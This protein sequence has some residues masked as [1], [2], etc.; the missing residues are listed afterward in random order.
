MKAFNFSGSLTAGLP[1]TANEKFGKSLFLGEEGRGRRYEW[2][3]LDNRFPP[4]VVGDRVLECEPRKVT[5]PPKDGKPEKVFYVLEKAKKV[6]SSVLVRINTE[7]TYTR[8]THGRMSVVE[9]TPETLVSGSGAYGDAGRIGVWVDSLVVM[10]PGDAVKVILSGGSKFEPYAIWMEKDGQEPQTSTWKEYETL[11]A[12]TEA[13]ALVSQTGLNVLFGQMPAYNWACGKLELGIELAN[14]LAGQA[15]KLGQEGR[16]RTQIEL[17]LVNSSVE[18]KLTEAAV[19]KL[20]EKVVPARYFGDEPTTK[21]F[22]G[23]TQVPEKE[24]GFLVKISTSWVYTRGSNAEVSTW[25]GNPTFIAEG[26]G[27]EGAAGNIYSWPEVVV[28]LHE[29]DVIYIRPEG[30]Y[31]T[32]SSALFVKGGKLQS[33]VWL[34]WKIE[35]AKRDPQ[36]YVAKG[37]APLGHVPTDWIGKVVTVVDV[38]TDRDRHSQYLDNKETGEVIS[39]NP[40]ILNLGWDGQDRSDREITH[41]TWIRLETEKQVKRLEGAE[42]EKRAQVRAKL[43]GLMAKAKMA[44]EKSYFGLAED[45]LRQ[46]IYDVSRCFYYDPDT[47]P[48]DLSGLGYSLAGFIEKAEGIMGRFGVVEPELQAREASG[49]SGE[50]LPDYKVSLGGSKN[51][52]AKETIW[53]IMPDGTVISPKNVDYSEAKFGDLP[54]TVLVVSWLVDNYGY[55]YS[56]A[57]RVKYL[58]KGVTDAQKA[59]VVKLEQSCHKY[60]VGGKTGW[61]LTEKEVYFQTAYERDFQGEEK[62]AMKGMASSIW[63]ENSTPIDLSIWKVMKS[64]TSGKRTVWPERRTVGDPNHPSE[65]MASA[66]KKAVA[67]NLDE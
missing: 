26:R 56:E 59:K 47:L 34:N 66:Y 25:K 38:A 27:A 14:G 37:T 20:S 1:L 3:R 57:W 40:L 58:P 13:Q 29:G 18:G 10:K 43:E 33:E 63:A 23:L 2:V 67:K 65:V 53:A 31:K 35:D 62:E 39:I 50:I 36:F 4:E 17:P 11:K 9:G 22:Y 55:R 24:K 46:E 16:G 48:T 8:D 7:G 32:Q 51:G 44:M 21:V 12:V 60:F 28:I 54:A 45:A 52:R 42:L 49:K 41:G 19:V 5:L 6:S 30:G 15:V 64:K 61:D